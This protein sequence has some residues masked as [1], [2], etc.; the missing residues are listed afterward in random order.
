MIQAT[1]SQSCS[2]PSPFANLRGDGAQAIRR[3][4]SPKPALC[5]LSVSSMYS[6]S[7]ALITISSTMCPESTPPVMQSCVDSSPFKGT[8]GQSNAGEL[9]ERGGEEGGGV[10]ARRAWASLLNVIRRSE[11]RLVAYRCAQVCCERRGKGGGR[12]VA[13]CR[14]SKTG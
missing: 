11:T 3:Y 6:L 12:D 2:H 13:S 7:V 10:E 1:P 14:H 5:G 9:A 8:K 4:L